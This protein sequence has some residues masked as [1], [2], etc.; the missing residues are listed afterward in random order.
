MLQVAPETLRLMTL[1]HQHQ[2]QHQPEALS[3]R[4][5][6]PRMAHKV[7]VAKE[8]CDGQQLFKFVEVTL[9]S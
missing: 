9:S 5:E 7:A 2:H 1:R 8:Q 6:A 3:T 4:L